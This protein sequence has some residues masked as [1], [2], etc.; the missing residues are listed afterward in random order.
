M[1]CWIFPCILAHYSA[2]GI[3]IGHR[4]MMTTYLTR[5]RF[6]IPALD[7][8]GDL[9]QL[10]PVYRSAISGDLAKGGLKTERSVPSS[11]T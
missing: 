3:S 6:D 10:T 8:R 9:G 11:D 2:H 5:A 7:L 1:A 4:R